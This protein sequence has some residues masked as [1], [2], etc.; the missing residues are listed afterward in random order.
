[1]N[2]KYFYLLFITALQFLS[3]SVQAQAPQKFNYQAVARNASGAVIANQTV[4]IRFTIHDATA[5]GT[6]VYAETQAKTTSSLGLFTAEVGGGTV[7]SGTMSTINWGSGAKYLEVEIDPNG[8]TSYSI[9]GTSELLSVPYALFSPNVNAWNI[10]GNSGTNPS[11]HFIGTTDAQPLRFKVNNM[12]AGKLDYDPA[13]A[14]TSFGFKSLF[15]N[16]TGHSNTAN[17]MQALYYNTTG[18]SNTANGNGALY[19]NT[20]GSANTANGDSAL[21]SNTIGDYNTA[22]GYQALNYNTTG[23]ENT[24]NGYHALYSNTI[25]NYNTANGMQ[26]LYSNTM[27]TYNTANGYHALYSNTTGKYNTANGYQALYSNTIGD[28]NTANGTSALYSNTTGNLNTA[29]GYRALSSNTIGTY[30]I[31]AGYRAG[32][33][34]PN[35]VNNTTCLGNGAGF[36]TTGSNQV[37]IGNMSVTSIAGQ[38]SWSNYSDAR[39]KRDIQHNVPGLAFITRLHPVTYHLDIHKQ[40]E[41]ANN[42]K[43][44]ESADYPEKYEIEQLTMT[45]FLAQEVEQAAQNCHYDF[46]GVVAPKDG[47]GLY[48]LRYSE[49]V[50]PLVKAVQEQQAMIDELKKSNQALEKSNSELKALILQ[51][52]ERK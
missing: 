8:G 27:G 30:N 7:V 41:I 19:S 50:M 29:N 12:P 37:N 52:M 33:L 23:D 45:G 13:M 31:G 18:S 48:S 17:G 43:K 38:V 51:W 21:N 14:N 47:K 26:A 20:T 36:G 35:N 40:Y 6:I 2:A 16:T 39:I 32:S 3:V 22:N 4:G 42:G 34:L 49:F 25:G 24:A 44:D 1:M 46:S 15:S 11:T 5:T 10:N 28:Y 9:N